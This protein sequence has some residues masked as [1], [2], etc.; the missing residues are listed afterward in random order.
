[1]KAGGTADWERGPE[2][3]L[4]ML[5][6]TLC[7]CERSCHLLASNNSCQLVLLVTPLQTDYCFLLLV[8][9]C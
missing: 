5:L 4:L 7:F 9:F 2:D 1:M 6:I 8:M 3:N